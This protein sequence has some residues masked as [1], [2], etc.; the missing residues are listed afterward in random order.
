MGTAA[1]ETGVSAAPAAPVAGITADITADITAGHV[2]AAMAA[3]MRA[4]AITTA[5][6]GRRRPMPVEGEAARVATCR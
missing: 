4:A 1:A 5:G 3:T 6:A 2:R